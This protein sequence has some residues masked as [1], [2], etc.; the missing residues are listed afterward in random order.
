MRITERHT[1]PSVSIR[2]GDEIC[3]YGI[4]TNTGHS[5]LIYSDPNSGQIRTLQHRSPSGQMR[6]WCI[7]R[8]T[9]TIK[10][11]GEEYV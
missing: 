3:G 7:R 1:L 8:T 4:I 9:E 6:W 10:Y 5:G 2:V 11:G